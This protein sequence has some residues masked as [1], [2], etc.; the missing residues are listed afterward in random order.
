[1]KTMLGFV[2]PELVATTDRKGLS[3]MDIVAV[4]TKVIQAQQLQIE[5]LEAGLE[6]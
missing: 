2:L 3:A 6:D 1:M 4:P 5:A